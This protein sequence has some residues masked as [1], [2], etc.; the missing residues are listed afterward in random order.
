MGVALKIIED[1]PTHSAL[2]DDFATDNADWGTEEVLEFSTE[3]YH[4]LTLFVKGKAHRIV[5]TAGESQ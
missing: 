3:L 1:N 5:D 2:Q 4:V